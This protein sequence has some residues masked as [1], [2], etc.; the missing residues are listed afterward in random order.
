MQA[1]EQEPVAFPIP[2]GVKLQRVSTQGIN[3]FLDDLVSKARLFPTGSTRQAAVCAADS[4]GT[5][6]VARMPD[7]PVAVGRSRARI[8]FYEQPSHP[9]QLTEKS[10]G[11]SVPEQP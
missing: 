3:R 5:S 9:I 6:R 11:S 2:G 7:Y 1:D 8:C 4:R 10:P